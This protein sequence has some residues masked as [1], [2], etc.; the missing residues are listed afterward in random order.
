ML[1]TLTRQ[2]PALSPPGAPCLPLP[3]LVAQDLCRLL[4]RQVF[5]GRTARLQLV[6]CSPCPS[7]LSPS[8]APREKLLLTLP[9]VKAKLLARP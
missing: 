3:G 1:R 5:W 8:S 2:P 4:L 9:L 7:V 6:S